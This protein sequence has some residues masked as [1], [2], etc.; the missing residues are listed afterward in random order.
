MLCTA[1]LGIKVFSTTSHHITSRVLV[2]ITE[3]LSAPLDLVGLLLLVCL[4]AEV[5]THE[6]LQILV[7]IRC[8]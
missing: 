5:Q 3:Y 8:Q 7:N 4:A 6:F 1:C 2:F